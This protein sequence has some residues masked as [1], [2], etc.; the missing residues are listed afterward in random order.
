MINT[1]N[2]FMHRFPLISYMTNAIDNRTSSKFTYPYFQ[3]IQR[4]SLGFFHLSK[5]RQ[6]RI[7]GFRIHQESGTLDFLP[8]MGAFLH[9]RPQLLTPGGLIIRD[10]E[11]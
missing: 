4:N 8:V 6:D 7:I 2:T 5:R 11:L 9:K 10:F 1:S 3:S